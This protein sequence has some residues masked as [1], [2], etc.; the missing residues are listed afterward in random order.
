MRVYLTAIALIAAPSAHAMDAGEQAYYRGDYSRSASLLLAEANAGRAIAQSFLGYQ[1]QYGLGV[2]KSYEEAAHWYLCAAE[3]GEPTAQFFLGQLYDRGQ[4]VR[5]DP[6]EAEKWLDL[7]AAHAPRD[8]R[9]YW[10]SMRD[11][12]GGKM[13]LDELAEARRR[14]VAWFADLRLLRALT[15]RESASANTQKIAGAKPTANG[16]F[17]SRAQPRPALTARASASAR[18]N[19]AATSTTNGSSGQST[20]APATAASFTSPSPRPSRPRKRR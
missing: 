13:T 7:A 20:Q 5:E 18:P 16:S 17:V 6:V 15:R 14:A 12:I 8:R 9:E 3:Q 19:S 10:A 1:F 11:I 4:G 2:P